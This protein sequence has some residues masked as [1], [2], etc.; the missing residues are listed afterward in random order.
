L[1][2][3]LLDYRSDNHYHLHRQSKPDQIMIVC[4]C[5]R[6]SDKTIERAT[7]AG[8][9][10]DDIQLELGVATQCGKCEGCA[11]ALW[12]EC[13]S[14]QKMAHLSRELKTGQPDLPLAAA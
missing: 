10:F 7:R 12:S 2:P 1:P 4:V 6:V 9:S 13:R 8:A 11:R 5:H 14:S 3:S